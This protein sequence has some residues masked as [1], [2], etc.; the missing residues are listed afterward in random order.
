MIVLTGATGTI[1]RELVRL[2][3]AAGHPVRALSRR[4]PHAP[5]DNGAEW[6]QVD[7]TDRAALAASLAGGTR[8]FLLTGN[9]EDMVRAQ[10]N[11]VRAAVDAGV[12]VV[13][14]LSALGA[15]DH[16]RSVVGLWHFN[17]ERE[18]RASGLQWTVLRPHHFMQN[19]LEPMVYDR[20][21]GRVYS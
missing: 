15:S 13:V 19:F 9:A 4:P 20:V 1:G 14:K 21:A 16:S 5:A 8:L 3:S 10:K 12:P 11:A 7:M 18:L 6:I 17:V 2:L